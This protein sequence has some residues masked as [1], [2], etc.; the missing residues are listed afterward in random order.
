[1]T[2][3]AVRRRYDIIA[4]RCRRARNTAQITC[5]AVRDNR[6][7]QQ[8]TGPELRRLARARMRGEFSASAYRSVSAEKVYRCAIILLFCRE[9]YSRNQLEESL[10]AK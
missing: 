4:T 10:F 8:I 6:C 2:D 9:I 7:P 1:M 5:A 3:R